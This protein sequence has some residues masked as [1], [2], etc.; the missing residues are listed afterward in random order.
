MGDFI[1]VQ[2]GKEMQMDVRH[3]QQDGK[4]FAMMPRDQVA[5]FMQACPDC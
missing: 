2:T 5:T 1:V 3:V 4:H